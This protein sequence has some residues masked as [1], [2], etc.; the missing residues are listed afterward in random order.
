MRQ[1]ALQ[2]DE[3]HTPRASTPATEAILVAEVNYRVPGP[4]VVSAAL[5]SVVRS[6]PGQPLVTLN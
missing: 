5:P 4:Y 1:V 6:N 3:W 2:Y